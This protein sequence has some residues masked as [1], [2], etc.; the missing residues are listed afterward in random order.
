MEN[1][2]TN[3]VCVHKGGSNKILAIIA[4]ILSIISITIS[5]FTLG[6]ISSCPQ[7]NRNM[8]TTRSTQNRTNK[9]NN[10]N[11]RNNPNTNQNNMNNQM[12]YYGNFGRGRKNWY[13]KN[14]QKKRY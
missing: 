11:I 5:A 1:Q 7:M 12:R 14:Y 8:Y 4:I 9:N 2:E 10:R 6:K 13:N 3:N